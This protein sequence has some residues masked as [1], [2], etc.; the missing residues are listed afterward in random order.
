M[1]RVENTNYGLTSKEEWH[2]LWMN[3][4]TSLN[5]QVYS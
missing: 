2:L 5:Q 4:T 3:R 1:M